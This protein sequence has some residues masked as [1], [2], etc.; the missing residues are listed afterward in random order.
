MDILFILFP[1]DWQSSPKE[2]PA[3]DTISVVFPARSPI[4]VIHIRIAVRDV[5]PEVMTLSLQAGVGTQFEVSA[6]PAVDV[7]DENEDPDHPAGAASLIDEGSGVYHIE[8]TFNVQ[9]QQWTLFVKNSAD[10]SAS[11]S[12]AAAGTTDP[13]SDTLRPWIDLPKVKTILEAQGFRP[14]PE[15]AEIRF[16]NLG[17]ATLEI[18]QSLGQ[19]LPGDIFEL[20]SVEPDVVD[21]GGKGK[22]VFR[23]LEGKVGLLDHKL[24]CND[25]DD[26]HRRIQI[27]REEPKEIPRPPGFC[28]TCSQRPPGQPQCSAFLGTPA[29][30]NSLCQRTFCRHKL[31]AH[32]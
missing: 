1:D 12:V 8:I 25:K 28:H 14:A 4:G 21:P 17:T 26:D 15:S 29:G 23:A 5:D 9:D 13:D 18:T 19:P 16:C 27:Q 3:G 22:L 24:E 2:V 11:I 20:D 7:L 30:P 10:T 31:V 6:G 32:S